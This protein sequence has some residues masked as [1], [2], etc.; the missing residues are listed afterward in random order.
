MMDDWET[1]PRFEARI[2]GAFYSPDH[3]DGNIRQGFVSAALW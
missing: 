2:T 3:T 1:S